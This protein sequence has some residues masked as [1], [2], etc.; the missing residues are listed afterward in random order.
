MVEKRYLWEWCWPSASQCECIE[1]N[2]SI[3][4]YKDK[5]LKRKEEKKEKFEK[6]VGKK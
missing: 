6:K 4:E 3:C 5:A 1:G 2:C